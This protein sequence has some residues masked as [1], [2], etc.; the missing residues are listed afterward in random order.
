M[1]SRIMELASQR[2]FYIAINTRL[3]QTLADGRSN[4]FP[5]G[6]QPVSTTDS[7]THE[8]SNHASSSPLAS[9]AVTSDEKEKSGL[10]SS[11]VPTSSAA[12]TLSKQDQE[13][14]LHAHFLASSLP[15]GGYQ[16][17]T[18]RPNYIPTNAHPPQVSQHDAEPHHTQYQQRNYQPASVDGPPEDGRSPA[19]IHEITQVT[20]SVHTPLTSYVPMPAQDADSLVEEHPQSR[21]CH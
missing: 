17:P 9:G 11:L 14:L 10:D 4:R 5:N 8:N 16:P 20:N 19:S 1:Q 13:S 2:E 18:S 12:T 3:R 21:H 7:P 6:V 15:P